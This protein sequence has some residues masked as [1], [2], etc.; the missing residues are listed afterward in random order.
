MWIGFYLEKEQLS[1]WEDKKERNEP[2]KK[3]VPSWG[4][5]KSRHGSNVS[6]SGSPA[7]S[8][9]AGNGTS[10]DDLRQKRETWSSP[11]MS[12][13]HPHQSCCIAAL[14]RVGMGALERWPLQ[15]SQ[16]GEELHLGENSCALIYSSKIHA[17]ASCWWPTVKMHVYRWRTPASRLG[18][19]R[20]REGQSL[21]DVVHGN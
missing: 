21:L 16:A 1:G 11:S 13:C 10:G 19:S 8:P 14:K 12:T 7:S 18:S 9:E 3:G 2:K 4:W 6:M 15:L 17:E 20:P 5:V